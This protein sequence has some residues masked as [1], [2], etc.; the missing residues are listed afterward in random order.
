MF[1][2]IKVAI[3]MVILHG[4]KTQTKMWRKNAVPPGVPGQ[5]KSE[6]SMCP[7]PTGIGL[8]PPCSQ[9]ACPS[10]CSL[11][12]C[13]STTPGVVRLPGGQIKGSTSSCLVK[14][15]PAST[16]ISCSCKWTIPSTSAPAN[17][18]YSPT[19]TPIHSPRFI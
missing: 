17:N 13:T 8:L 12:T 4:T 6:V 1:S 11:T 7:N 9:P 19:Q 14:T 15:C 10:T 16:P 5:S 2:F 18:I 3:D